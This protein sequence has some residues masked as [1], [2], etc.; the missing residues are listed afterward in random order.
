MIGIFAGLTIVA[1]VL[2]SEAEAACANCQYYVDAGYCSQ[3]HAAWMKQVCPPSCGFCTGATTA[4]VTT[5]EAP[6]SAPMPVTT[7]AQMPATT[8]APT[9]T[10][11]KTAMID[12][13]TCRHT[14]TLP[15]FY[16]VFLMALCSLPLTVLIAGPPVIA[17]KS[18]DES[19]KFHAKA[20]EVAV[21]L[22]KLVFLLPVWKGIY[23]DMKNVLSTFDSTRGFWGTVHCA[24]LIVVTGGLANYF[25]ASAIVC[26]IQS[27]IMWK[28]GHNGSW[29]G[30][31]NPSA[32]AGAMAN[33]FNWK[34]WAEVF[35]CQGKITGVMLMS[36]YFF[37]FPWG[38]AMACLYGIPCCIVY[39]WLLG[40]L[41]VFISKC[42]AERVTVWLMGFVEKTVLRNRTRETEDYDLPE[43]D[44]LHP[45]PDDKVGFVML[46]S[47]F[48]C[49]QEFPLDFVHLYD[50]SK[51]TPAEFAKN[52]REVWYP[53]NKHQFDAT[54]APG[55]GW[56]LYVQ[57]LVQTNF[58][59]QV[60]TTIMVELY[61]GS[62]YLEAISNTFWNRHFLVWLGTLV[63]KATHVSQE[64]WIY[65]FTQSF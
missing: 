47:W 7:P 49:V 18:A 28:S 12:L 21:L 58:A 52:L 53:K 59:A 13:D 25:K 33:G 23:T 1:I 46:V 36:A 35:E 14:S 62:G 27:R 29:M 63:A 64:A 65:V 45:E 40:T 16:T 6:T 54:G 50:L 17:R 24:N 34:V 3:A 5:T 10:T 19:A 22:S 38:F 57:Q 55:M 8:P 4:L 39:C 11:T 31:A 20:K 37:Y 26:L 2:Q 48:Q 43:S 60:S 32:S 56:Y 9:S 51:S 30:T 44:L 41:N 61:S 15:P 42:V